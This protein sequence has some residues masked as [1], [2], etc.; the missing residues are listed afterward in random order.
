M[1]PG[2]ISRCLKHK[3]CADYFSSCAGLTPEE[4]ERLLSFGGTVKP[5]LFGQ[6]IERRGGKDFH[7][8]PATYTPGPA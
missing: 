3:A 8:S 2:L 4:D 5:M 7:G 1:N 6:D